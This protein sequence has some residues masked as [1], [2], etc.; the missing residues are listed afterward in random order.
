MKSGIQNIPLEDLENVLDNIRAGVVIDDVEGNVVWANEFYHK[1]TGIDIKKYIG[2]T[3]WDIRKDQDISY[4]D[5]NESLFE[6]AI[7]AGKPIHNVLKYKTSDYIITTTAPLYSSDGAIKYVIC[8]LTNYTETITAQQ[9]LASAYAKINALETQMLELQQSRRSIGD[10]TVIHDKEMHKLYSMAFKL[11][12]TPISV[13]LLGE[14]GVGKD[15]LAKYIHNASDRKEKKFVHV[16]MS[17]I[18][19]ML[20]ESELFGYE[21]GAFTGAL[22]QGKEGL[23][24][25][26]NGGTLYLDEIGELPFDTQ[27]KLL[28]V[29]QN[30]SVRSVG[31]L[32]ETPI[33]IKII[34]ATNKNLEEMVEKGKFRMDLYYRLNVVELRIPPLRERPDDIPLLIKNFLGKY[35]KIY[36][37]SK[38]LAVETLRLLLQYNW[39]GN[40]R[41]LRHT[42]ESLVV[43]S[44]GSVIEPQYLPPEIYSTKAAGNKIASSVKLEH[45]SLKATMDQIEC[46][47]IKEAIDS[48]TTL[49]AAAASLSLDVSTLAKKR[50]KYGI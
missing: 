29:I 47:L 20:F 4:I 35:N 2:K 31:G 9:K 39:P 49:S 19:P 1:I 5:T 36:K 33:D 13:M 32:E 45:A 42:I 46:Q 14:T 16:N 18:P 44:T 6:L 37:T 3:V 12:R 15:V 50:K 25:L 30:K 41:E 34:S 7:K 11:A 48:S 10:E 22:K 21:P 23:I 38:T 40:V 43:T 24:R 17:A 28:Q 26:A 27:A 8:T